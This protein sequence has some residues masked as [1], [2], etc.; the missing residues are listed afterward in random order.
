VSDGF[1]FESVDLGPSVRARRRAPDRLTRALAMALGLALAFSVGVRAGRAS[2]PSAP[3]TAKTG[4]PA[5]GHPAPD[6]G[7][8]VT[9]RVGIVDRDVLYVTD[10]GGR[11]VKVVV[12]DEAKLSTVR[13][14]SLA[15][16]HVG[17]TVVVEGRRAPDGTVS[18]TSVTDDGLQ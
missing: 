6:P 8:A 14:A 11:M 4:S 17:D 10:A 15:D 5:E 9:G 18:A 3:G 13:A 7:V 1:D 16:L 2:R 12:T